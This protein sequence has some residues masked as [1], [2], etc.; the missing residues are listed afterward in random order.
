MKKI[1][2]MMMSLMM[3]LAL[4]QC[5]PDNGDESNK[6][7]PMIKVSCTVPI[8]SDGKSEFD[9]LMID[10]KI[11]WS[12]DTERI[13]LA[14]PNEDN[15]QIVE[16]TASPTSESDVLVFEGKVAERIVREGEYDLW[17]LGDSK[18]SNSPYYTE[19]K[20][21]NTITGISGSIANQSGSMDDL[22]YCH[23]AKTT[24]SAEIIEFVMVLTLK[25]VLESQ[26]AIAHLDLEGITQLRGSVIAGTEY[27]LEYDDSEKSFKF[28][29]TEGTDIT[30]TQGSN[31][32]YVVFFQNL[33]DNVYLNSNTNKKITFKN[34]VKASYIYSGHAD[35]EGY[36]PLAW[37]DFGFSVTTSEVSAITTCSAVCGGEVTGDNANAVTERG[38]CW[39]TSQNP[40]IY[41]NK[42]IDGSGVGTYT[43][44][45][46][47]LAS[48]TTYYV[49]AYAK[50]ETATSYGEQMSFTTDNSFVNGHEFVDLGLPS[51]LLWAT[52]NIGANSPEEY[53]NYYAWGNTEPASKYTENNCYTNYSGLDS[54]FDH[55]RLSDAGYIDENDIL[56]PQYDAATA[57][58]GAGWR[59]HTRQEQEEL[60][61]NCTWEWTTLNGINGYK[62]TGPNGNS[63]FLPAAGYRW[64]DELKEGGTNGYYW[65]SSYRPVNYAYIIDIYN[66]HYEPDYKLVPRYYGLS[67]RPVIKK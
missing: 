12:A 6:E 22:G 56:T 39:S 11:K 20:N 42:T 66:G 35:G 31:S 33:T 61:D 4:S 50:D 8:N 46:T 63:I 40:T 64:H 38:V 26:I 60:C 58:W 48:N 62:V 14:V 44:N 29:N 41:D 54:D 55:W 1:T 28:V 3:V 13:Y 34:G 2:A 65:G 24:V 45:L 59:M 17:Y 36:Q 15:P 51:G 67:V 27:A 19:I 52:C 43:S 30:V 9:N 7:E 10:G 47:N 53:G 23:I 16:L 49:R 21:G 57:N 37:E 32:S 5:K 25:G 18:N